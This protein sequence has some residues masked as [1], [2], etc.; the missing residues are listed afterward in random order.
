MKTHY[1]FTSELS[2]YKILEHYPNPIC[3]R[4]LTKSGEE[5]RLNIIDDNVI[6]IG[7]MT[8]SEVHWHIG[9]R[10][11]QFIMATYKVGWFPTEIVAGVEPFYVCGE[12]R[13]RFTSNHEL[14]QHTGWVQSYNTGSA[15]DVFLKSQK[16]NL[17]KRL[18]SFRFKVID[19]TV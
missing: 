10:D 17:I 16:E 11:E 9:K 13:G 12:F 14:S 2:K 7:D 1:V 15:N 4:A 5:V 19:K 6:E 8:E 3:K 18:E